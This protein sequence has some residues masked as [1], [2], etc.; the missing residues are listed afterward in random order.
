MPIVDVV[1]Q[2][3]I[4]I[5]IVVVAHRAGAIIVVIVA[6]HTIATII[7]IIAH[8]TPSLS[9]RMSS[10]VALYIIVRCAI[11]III[12]MITG[13]TRLLTNVGRRGRRTGT[14]GGY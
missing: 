1:A 10:P 8:V 14:E 5:V 6:H 13:I 11:A 4:A 7:F 3:A 2:R 9:S 12:D